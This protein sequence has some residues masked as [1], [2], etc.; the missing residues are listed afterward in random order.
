[1]PAS[2]QHR[3]RA[4]REWVKE[5]ANQKDRQHVVLAFGKSESEALSSFHD[6]KG[7]G[8]QSCVRLVT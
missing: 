3:K 6:C 1:M 8:E 2:K 4:R 5:I 7:Q